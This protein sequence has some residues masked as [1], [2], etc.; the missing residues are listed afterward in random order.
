MFQIR[1]EEEQQWRKDEAAS[2]SYNCPVEATA[3]PRRTSP[4]H[5]KPSDRPSLLSLPELIT[6]PE[7]H[8]A[9]VN[10]S[11]QDYSLSEE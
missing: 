10:Q 11:S 4:G 2:L 8:G 9:F 1:K 6:E 3:I 5:M 7:K